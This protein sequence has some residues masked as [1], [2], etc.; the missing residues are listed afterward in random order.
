MT[1]THQW[2][3]L[4]KSQ[5]G[6]YAEYLVKMELTLH[7]LDVYTAEVD[8]K[9]IDFVIRKDN[10]TYFDIQ[11]KSSRNLTYVFLPKDKFEPSENLYAALVLFTDDKPPELYLIPSLAWQK[12]NELLVDHDY[13]GLKSVPEYGINL[14]RRNLVILQ[15]FAFDKIVNRLKTDKD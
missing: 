10:H 14:S 15:Q 2:S 8:D 13:A 12:P 4:S 3:T 5:L 1:L 6:R 9:G 7:G 11:V